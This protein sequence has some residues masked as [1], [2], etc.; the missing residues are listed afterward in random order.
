MSGQE[1]RQPF[2]AQRPA[3]ARCRVTLQ[4]GKGDIAADICKNGLGPWPK[5][6][7]TGFQWF[8]AVTRWLTRS[9]RLLTPARRARVSSR[10]GART[11]SLC[12]LSRRY[13][14]ITSA[15]SGSSLPR[16]HL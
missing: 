9:S 6:V 2:L 5:G 8:W 1:S 4:E 16:D 10:K 14:A 13:S 11:V 7:Q 3:R 12:D 15:S